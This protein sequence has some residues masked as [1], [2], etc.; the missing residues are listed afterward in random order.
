MQTLVLDTSGSFTTVLVVTD[1]QLSSSSTLQAR[2]AEHLH[3]QI[4]SSLKKAFIQPQDLDHIAVVIGPG[5]WT[6]LNIGVTTAKTLAQVLEIP[7][8]PIHT[9]DVL[10][11]HSNAPVWG[12]M[13]AGRDRCYYAVYSE[14]KQFDMKVLPIDSVVKEIESDPVC[15]IEY[16][17]NFADRFVNYKQY[18]NTD[19]LKPEAL[20]AA[21]KEVNALDR[22]STKLLTPVYLQP[23]Y[24]EHEASA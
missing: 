24:E 2:P 18:H 19:R 12:I 23:S 6:G 8:S 4:D 11:I 9:L 22:E 17:H 3:H 13:Y 20:I 16:G 10:T 1:G 14:S 21:A 5:S 7:V 15:V